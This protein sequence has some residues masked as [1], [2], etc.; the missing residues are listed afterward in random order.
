MNT[1]KMTKR[2]Y[3]RETARHALV[4]LLLGTA[5]FTAPLTTFGYS[6][7]LSD[8]VLLTIAYFNQAIY[9]IISL[10]IV[11]FIWNIYH[12]FIVSDPE[13]KKDAGLY[14]MYSVIGLFVI[15]SFWGL[16]NIV[17]N[18]LNLNNARSS[19]PAFGNTSAGS[20]FSS[21][22]SQ[23]GTQLNIFGNGGASGVPAGGF[24]AGGASGVPA[25]AGSR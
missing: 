12:Y 4:R 13:N 20:Y 21:G 11:T 22:S 8:L 19:I 10:A 25:G 3:A 17:G 5:L 15:I 24:G 6:R 9:L 7:S 14:V 1:F 16:V 18:S 23:S 2:E